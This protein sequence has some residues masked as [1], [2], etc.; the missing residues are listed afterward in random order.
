M[1]KNGTTVKLGEPRRIDEHNNQ[2]RC[3][4]KPADI[5]RPMT[6]TPDTVQKL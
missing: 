5:T 6:L 1:T 3:T 4:D 2:I